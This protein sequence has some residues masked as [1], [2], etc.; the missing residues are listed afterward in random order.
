MEEIMQFATLYAS[1]SRYKRILYKAE[2]ADTIKSLDIKLNQAFQLFG[3]SF[4]IRC[5]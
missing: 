3:V 1:R 4:W 5:R 2:D